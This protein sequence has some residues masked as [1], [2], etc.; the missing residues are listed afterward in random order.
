MV[1]LITLQQTQGECSIIF[2]PSIQ[3]YTRKLEHHLQYIQDIRFR[4]IES[5][6]VSCCPTLENRV[7]IYITQLEAKLACLHAR[8]CAL[9][10]GAGGEW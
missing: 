8:L 9:I 6:L 4:H 5:H 7:F 10:V 1:P 3:L 2:R